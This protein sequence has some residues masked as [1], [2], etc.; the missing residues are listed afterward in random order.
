[1]DGVQN[2][3]RTEGSESSE[4]TQ[5]AQRRIRARDDPRDGAAKYRRQHRA[6]DG[7]IKRIEKWPDNLQLADQIF[8]IAKS[9]LIDLAG[10]LGGKKT[11]L[12]NRIERREDEI[13]R[14][15][16]NRQHHDRRRVDT[17]PDR[18]PEKTP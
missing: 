5:R 17:Q 8:I 7:K 9:E 4:V 2:E 10:E 3:R 12:N 16:R 11:C 6:A 13:S 14:N 18:R 15:Q 1:T